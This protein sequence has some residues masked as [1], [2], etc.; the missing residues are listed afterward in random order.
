MGVCHTPFRRPHTFAIKEESAKAQ[1][2]DKYRR[3]PGITTSAVS[4]I[5]ERKKRDWL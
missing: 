3:L 5:I 1:K 4:R 2:R